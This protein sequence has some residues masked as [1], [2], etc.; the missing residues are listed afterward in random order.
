MKIV[1][2]VPFAGGEIEYRS[3]RVCSNPQA[4]EPVSR[5]NMSRCAP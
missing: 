1:S 4:G 5:L 3:D 2:M